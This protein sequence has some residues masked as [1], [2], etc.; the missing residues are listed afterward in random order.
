[1]TTVFSAIPMPKGGLFARKPDLFRSPWSTTDAPLFFDPDATVVDPEEPDLRD[2]NTALRALTDI[3]PDVQPEVFREMLLSLGEESRVAVVTEHLLRD[4]AKWVRG[5]YRKP[6]GREQESQRTAGSKSTAKEVEQGHAYTLPVEESF[7][8]ECYRQAVKM[9]FYQEFKSLSHSTIKAVMAEHNYSYTQARPTLQDLTSKSWRAALSNFWYRKKSPTSEA[10]VHPLI[11]WQQNLAGSGEVVPFLKPTKSPQLNRELYDTLIA[12][13]IARTREEQYRSD[14]AL[15]FQINDAEAEEAE[16]LYDCECCYT[17]SAFE[18][19][20]TC[21]DGCH[22]ICFR[23]IRHAVNE[24]L[25]GQGW[26]RN[27]DLETSS[28]RCL[29][30][31]LEECHGSVPAPFV[32]RA[33]LE[34]KD[35]EHT[36]RKLQDR[37]AT[38]CLLKTQ[39]PLLRCPFCPYAEVDE[40]P[41]P[42]FKSLSALQEQLL[43]IT[44]TPFLSFMLLLLTPFLYPLIR[45]VFAIFLP[46]SPFLPH[47]HASYTRI[48]HRRRGLKFICR[49]PLC[50]QRSCLNCSTT[51]TD[52]HNCSSNANT[53]LLSL[54]HAIEAATTSSI[55]RTCPKCHLSFVKSSGCNK[56]VCTCG[57]TMCYVCRSEIGKE[58]YTHFCQHFRERGGRC[59]ECDRCDLYVTEDEDV[60]LRRA[61][62]RAEKEWMEVEGRELRLRKGKQP[63]PKGKMGRE[64]RGW[65]WIR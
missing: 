64:L 21:N 55:K 39:L 20:S 36:W 37:S 24:A 38:E 26:A 57:Y 6:A 43:R 62:E 49:S 63:G 13:S 35:G 4:K 14:L 59:A 52:P 15:A 22:Y 3:F 27:I 53:P 30:P 25:F 2:L 28:V 5:R 51:W 42:R 47:L 56:L 8:S 54:R 33:L 7:R 19:T 41:T 12:P 23:C 34:E 45:T 1:M 29:A 60:V 40:L 48:A 32:Q 16:A 11:I 9:A 65:G 61:A 18:Q 10:D 17:P 44:P 58:G 31:T 50:A 46:L